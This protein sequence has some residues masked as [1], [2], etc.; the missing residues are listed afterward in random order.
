MGYTHYWNFGDNVNQQQYDKSLTNMTAIIKRWQSQCKKGG[1]YDY[2]R[3]SGHSAHVPG[4]YPGILINGKQDQAHERFT[5]DPVPSG[6]LQSCK[7]DQKP[8]DV[9]VTACLLVLKHRLKG[10]VDLT[11]D[12]TVE[13]WEQGL[14]LAIE[15]TGLKLKIPDSIKPKYGNLSIVS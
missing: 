9:V 8:Y 12:G 10:S 6:G 2:C 11:S 4:K 13:N 15:V 14:A 7:T 1:P 5:L 3:L